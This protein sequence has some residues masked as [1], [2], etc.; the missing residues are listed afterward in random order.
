MGHP[1]CSGAVE[2]ILN[3][4]ARFFI[5]FPLFFGKY[6][7]ISKT[8]NIQRINTHNSNG[9]RAPPK[10]AIPHLQYAS[11]LIKLATSQQILGSQ[12]LLNDH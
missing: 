2:V 12:S 6:L 4:A 11:L 5:L 9:C 10:C 3:V 7:K 1:T 8:T